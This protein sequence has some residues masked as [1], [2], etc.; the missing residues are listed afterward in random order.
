MNLMG[1]Y[2][3]DLYIMKKIT[4]CT[5]ISVPK[6]FII[7]QEIHHMFLDIVGM[8][9]RTTECYLR[10]QLKWYAVFDRIPFIYKVSKC[11]FYISLLQLL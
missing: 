3:G 4:Q 11:H 7:I 8:T 10:R 2:C 1:N 9:F 6:S 5:R